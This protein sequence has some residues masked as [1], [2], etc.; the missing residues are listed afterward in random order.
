MATGDKF[1]AVMQSDIGASGAGGVAGYDAMMAAMDGKAPA[2]YGLGDRKGRLI[3]PSDTLL[4]HQEAGWYYWEG[5][6][7]SDAPYIYGSMLVIPG[8][9]TIQICWSQAYSGRQVI[10]GIGHN[11][12]VA[13]EWEWINP[14]LAL[15]TEYRTTERFNGKPVYVRAV[16]CGAGP[17][18]DGIKFTYIGISETV[19]VE[20]VISVSGFVAGS[21]TIPP[22]G[23]RSS[24]GL[25]ITAAPSTGTDPKYQI[26]VDTMSNIDASSVTIYAIVKYTKTS[27]TGG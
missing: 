23:S 5:Q 21:Y 13:G 17:T 10:R 7:P 18:A 11:G 19:A 8:T 3:S 15:G 9:N 22:G 2:G 16:N 27:D 4:A 24:V 1:G 14:P 6:A 12:T 20:N 25:Y 26:A